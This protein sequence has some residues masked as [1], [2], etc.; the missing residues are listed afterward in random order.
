MNSEN[1]KQYSPSL[2]NKRLPVDQVVTA[3]GEYLAKNSDQARHKLLSHTFRF[4]DLDPE[5]SIEIMYSDPKAFSAT[6]NSNI[7][8][9]NGGYWQ[10]GS[11]SDSS[12]MSEHFCQK[13]VI[14][15]AVGYTIAPKA[16]MSEIFC[17]VERAV[18]KILENSGKSEVFICGHSA[19]GHLASMLLFSDFKRIY[20]VDAFNLKGIISVSGIF[21]LRP[22]L[23][24]DINDNLKMDLEESRRLSPMLRSDLRLH[25]D[26]KFLI[27]YAQNDS[28]AFHKQSEDFKMHLSKSLGYENVKSIEI[29]DFDHF[30]II[31]NIS[32]DDFILTKEIYKFMKV[33]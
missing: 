6:E 29:K 27:V 1:Q 28:P 19:G 5:Q 21:D 7:L 8:N 31:E 11:V 3:H 30:N 26:V 12:F 25:K 13:N 32:R 15:V 20:H 23:E 24:T 10:W 16:C 22:L 2:W 9:F 17:Q 33:D 14:T 4:S 18:A